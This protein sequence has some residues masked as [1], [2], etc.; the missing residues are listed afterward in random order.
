[1]ATRRLA[2]ADAQSELT[3]ASRDRGAH[4]QRAEQQAESRLALGIGE[5]TVKTHVNNIMASCGANDRTTR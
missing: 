1:V 2:E 4:R 5:A 3:S